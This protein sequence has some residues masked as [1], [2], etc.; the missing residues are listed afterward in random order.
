MFRGTV[1]VPRFPHRD[2]PSVRMK[3]GSFSFERLPFSFVIQ[4][5]S[6]AAECAGQP[7]EQTAEQ[8]K[9]LENGGGDVC[10]GVCR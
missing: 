5:G 3:K 8:L 2:L 1:A 7:A 4:S 9:H 6:H 10:H